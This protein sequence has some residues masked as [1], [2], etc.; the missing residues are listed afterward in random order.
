MRTTLFPSKKLLKYA[1]PS[2]PNG[3][4]AGELP[5]G[6]LI[7]NIFQKG[8]DYFRSLRR[9]FPLRAFQHVVITSVIPPQDNWYNSCF[10]KNQ[11]L[12][13]SMG[14]LFSSREQQMPEH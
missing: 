4:K 6:Q 13:S 10:L 9:P 14:C 2:P 12:P 11:N 8:K 3:I 1:V 7:E 5:Q